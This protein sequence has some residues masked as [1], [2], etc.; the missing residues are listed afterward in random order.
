M[1]FY[2]ITLLI[3]IALSFTY[4]EQKITIKKNKLTS[5]NPIAYTDV[6]YKSKRDTVFVSTYSGKIYELINGEENKKQIAAINDEI[7]NLVYNVQSD[8]LYA[9]TLNSGVAII[10]ASTGAV[11]RTL[12]I[13]QT[14]A[15]RL[16]Y[17]E[18]NGILA[19]FDFKGNS[20]IWDIE[21]D[22]KLLETP[23]ELEQMRPKYI[24]GNGDIYFEG[25]NK[26]VRWNYRTKD[27]KP[28]K[29]N[30]HIADVDT[31]KNI[32]LLDGK[33]FTFYNSELDSILYK[34]KHPNWPIHISG[35]EGK[36]SIVNVPLSLEVLSGLANSKFIYTYGL[37]K[38]I[39]KWKKSSGDLVETYTRH[40][41]TISGMDSNKE[42]TQLVTVDLLGN[43]QFWNL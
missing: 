32:V 18:E 43:L 28:F 3:T 4:C 21:N 24:A 41:G 26:I 25:K 31:E 40:K 10:D 38:S 33:E 22:Y 42:K 34:Q 5:N 39:R 27:I 14:W 17:N 7:Y 20:Y 9:A 12:F 15:Y 36:D 19:T 6:V 13:E 30:G 23:P 8:E 11:K 1:K 29:I 2:K 35:K 37:D 16:C